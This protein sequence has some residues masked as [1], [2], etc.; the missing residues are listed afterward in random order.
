MRVLPGSP[1][2]A[3]FLRNHR[4]RRIGH[5]RIEYARSIL[6][7][8]E[9]AHDPVLEAEQAIGAPVEFRKHAATPTRG[10]ESSRWP[11]FI[12]QL[13]HDIW[14]CMNS[15]ASAGVFVKIRNPKRIWSATRELPSVGSVRGSLDTPKR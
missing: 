4:I 14:P 12:W 2:S 15:A 3:A 11:P 6:A 8:V 7:S 10:R 5:R 1:D 9:T 13:L